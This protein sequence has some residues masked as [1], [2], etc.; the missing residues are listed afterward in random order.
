MEKIDDWVQ[1]LDKFILQSSTRE[2]K[3]SDYPKEWNGLKIKVSF[4]MGTP[5]R[6]SWIAFLAPDMQTSNGFYPCYLYYKDTHI[7]VLAYGVSETNEF[8]SSW[9]TEITNRVPTID[10]YFKKTF[11]RYGDSFV[12]RVYNTKIE[13][14]KIKYFYYE[15]DQQITENNIEKDLNELITI[16]S[17]VLSLPQSV[18]INNYSQSAFYMEKELEDFLIENWNNT[19][20]GKKYDLITEEG[21][22]LSQQYKTDVGPIDIL[23]KDKANKNFV[24]I[25]LKKGKSSDDVVGQIARY[26]GWIKDKKGD[27]NVK[28]VI[29][30]GAYDRR[31]EFALKIVP[32]IEAF[33][34]KIDFK[35]SEFKP[36]R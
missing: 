17:K 1:I 10:S 27:K 14:N 11:P 6:V 4:G 15:T 18:T 12:F 26:M 16:Y 31:L 29:I 30:V 33:I 7:L 34:Y 21:E 35:L 3:T 36:D 5:A 20:L 23:A 25:E 28:G 2:L 32:N 13:E 24:V 22:P 19:L 8:G 9:P